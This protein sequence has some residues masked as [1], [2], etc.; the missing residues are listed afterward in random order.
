MSDN[1]DQDQA[2]VDLIV[3]T[4]LLDPNSEKDT[5]A[6]V[7]FAGKEVTTNSLLKSLGIYSWSIFPSLPPYPLQLLLEY[8]SLPITLSL[9][10]LLEYFLQLRLPLTLPR[11]RV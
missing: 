7:V 11:L 8:F 2:Q 6:L 4:Y 3:S 10:L 9:Q 1:P 5:I